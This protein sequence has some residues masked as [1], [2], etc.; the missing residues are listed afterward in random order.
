VPLL[1]YCARDACRANEVC[2][3]VKPSKAFGLAAGSDS[4]N[5]HDEVFLRFC[6]RIELRTISVVNVFTMGMFRS[7]LSTPATARAIPFASEYTRL[8]SA[9]DFRHL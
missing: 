7:A 5:L 6:S 8:R 2:E 3:R 9:F 4:S 1:A